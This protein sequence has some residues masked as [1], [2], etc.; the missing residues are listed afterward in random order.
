MAIIGQFY[1]DLIDEIKASAEGKVFEILKGLNPVMED[2]M[3]AECNSG[4]THE[5]SILDGY[6]DAVWG[7]LYKGAKASKAS[8]QQV[9][10]TTGWVESRSQ[11]EERLLKLAKDKAKARLSAA[12]PFLE[13]IAKKAQTA[14]FYANTDTNPEQIKGIGARFSA[15]NTNIPDP[16]KPNIANQVIHGGGAGNDCTSIFVVTWGEN[17]VSMLYPEGSKAGV[18]IKDRGT[19]PVQDAYGGTYYAK[20]TTFEQHL[21]VAMTDYRNSGAVRNIAVA[22]LLAGNVDIFKLMRRLKYRLNKTYGLGNSVGRTAIY[23]NRLVAEA[24][25][26]QSSDRAL[27]AARENYIPLKQAE[28]E[29][30]MVK[31]WDSIPVRITD[32]IINT[33]S[34]V[35]SVAI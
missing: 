34:A 6:P 33:E 9:E 27:I 22:D 7:R 28:L 10:D 29:G 30:Q 8:Y 32:G 25:E 26:D 35:P 5:H 3:F 11:I 31:F 19:E 15:Y 1:P 24:W 12:Q 17:S 23:V 20:V 16:D 2:A 14:F 4:K 21:G 18:E 13:V